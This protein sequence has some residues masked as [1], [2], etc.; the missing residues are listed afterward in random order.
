LSGAAAARGARA[1]AAAAVSLGARIETGVAA[2]ALRP[3]RFARSAD[4]PR[5]C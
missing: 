5:F 2:T 3:E 4:A 1:L